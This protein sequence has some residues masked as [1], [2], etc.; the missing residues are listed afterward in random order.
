ML[1]MVDFVVNQCY[2]TGQFKKAINWCKIEKSDFF[3]VIFQPLWMIFAFRNRA[4]LDLKV[5]F[6][7]LFLFHYHPSEIQLRHWS[8]H[9]FLK[10]I[11]LQIQS[12]INHFVLRGF[13]LNAHLREFFMEMR[14]DLLSLSEEWIICLKVKKYN[15]L[16]KNGIFG[17]KTSPILGPKWIFGQK[18]QLWNS[19]CF[20]FS[21]ALLRYWDCTE[22]LMRDDKWGPGVKS[23]L[24]YGTPCN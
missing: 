1:K 2:Q 22:D 24:F 5:I 8:W 17:S 13:S 15:F 21:K 9:P 10:I 14:R 20:T 19:A 18:L 7:V 4:V 16:L 6:S 3:L 12:L 23:S 11:C